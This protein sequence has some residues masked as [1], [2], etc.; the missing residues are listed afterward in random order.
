MRKIITLFLCLFI[1]NILHSQTTK[2]VGTGGNYSTLKLAFDAINSGTLTGAI[3]LQ[4]ISSTT[5]TTTANLNVSGSA[6]GGANYSSVLIYPT[7]SGY[8]IGSNI[9]SILINFN[10]AANVTI[11]GR[12]NLSGSTPDLTISN[13]SNSN[14]ATTIKYANSAS[15]NNIRYCNVL[16][17]S[18]GAGVATF[19]FS[20]S[21]SGS[22]IINNIIEYCNITNA[23]GNRPVNTILTSGTTGRENT[24]NIVRN[25]N[26]YNFLNPGIS[27][28]GVNMT[29]ASVNW[30][31]SGN[32][33]YETTSLI[34]NASGLTYSPIHISTLSNHTVSGNY[35]G[36]N[37]AQCGGTMTIN[38]SL[39]NYFCSIFITG[40]ATTASNVLN[41]TISN[42]NFTSTKDN[43]WDGIYI[44]D[45][46]VNV[47]G[48][49]IGAATGTNS[50]SITTPLASA[51]ATITGGVVNN[52]I[53]INVGGSGYTTAPLITFS[54]PPTGGTA[55][56][57]IATISGG[58]VTGI[59]VT[60]GGSGYVTAPSVYFDGIANNYSTSHG[61]IQNSNY[62]VNITNNNIGSITTVGSSSYSHGFESIYVRSVTG[63]TSFI[64]NVI[65]S[66][67]TPNS[68]HVSST[69]VNSLLKQDAYGIYSS[70]VGTTIITGNTIANITNEYSGINSG[71]RVRGIATIA[72]S[73]TITNNT[74]RNITTASSQFGN[75]T[76]A[77]IVGIAQTSSNTGTTQ[78]ITG[79]TVYSLSNSSASAKEDIYGIL[80][81]SPTA[82]TTTIS[83]NIIHSITLSSTNTSSYIIGIVLNYG[84]N[85]CVNN[86]VNLGVG[87]TTGYLISGI[88][89]E[90]GSGNNNNI[91]Y[92]TLYIGGT[93]SGTSSSTYA[94]YNSANT[95]TRNYKNN[96][97]MNVRSGGTT[98]NNFAVSLAGTANLLLDYNDYWAPGSDWLG[99]VGAQNKN[100]FTAFKNTTNQ[101]ANSINVDP[102]F[103]IAGGT[104]ISNYFTAAL[105]PGVAIT[106]ITT[107]FNGLSRSSTP[108]MGALENNNY[109]WQGGT[110]TD[111][112]TATNWTGGAVPPNGANITFA[113]SPNRNCVLDQ[114]RIIGDLT[115]GQSTYKFVVNG[116]QLTING[117]L[118][119]T[120]SAQIDATASSS[121]VVFAGTNAQSIPSSSFVSNT[122]DS[123]T[124][125]NANGLS[126][127]GDFT[128]NKGIA[129]IAGNFSLGPNTLTFNGIVTAMTGTVTGGSSTNMIIGGSGSNISMPAFILN[130]LTI[131]RT[132]GV[133]LYGNINISGVLTLTNGTLTVGANI[134]TLLNTPIRTNGNIDASN[135]GATLVFSNTS[136][137]TIPASI[138]TYA[139][140]NLTINGA[141]G[142]TASSGF[143]LNGILNLQSANPSNIKGC[144]DMW[145]GSAMDTLTMGAN[146][147]TIGTGDVTGIVTRNS[148]AV[149]TP[150]SF[151]NQFT[152]MNMSAGGALPNIVSCKITLVSSDLT[153]KTNAIHRYYDFIRTGGDSLTLVTLNL[154]YLNSELN[155]ATEGNLDLFDYHVSNVHI[156]D[157]GR[158]NDNISDKWVGLANLSLT[159]VCK[160]NSFN[161]KY[162][163]LGTSTVSSYTWVGA[164]TDWNSTANWAGGVVPVSGNHVVIPDASTTLYSPTLPSSTTIGSILIQAGGVLNGGTSTTLTL[165]AANNSWDNMGTFNAGTS[166]V[167]FTNANATMSDPTNFYNITVADGAKLTLSTDNIMRVSNV[168]SLSTTGVLNAANNHNTIEYNGGSQTIAFP[169]GSTTGY[170][171]LI[172]S[173]SGTKTMPSTALSIYGDFTISGT[174]TV[175][176]ASSINLAGEL[177]IGD[178]ATFNTGN[179][180]HY[181]SD[182]FDNS[183]IFNAAPGYTI[184]LNGII[185][186][187]IYGSSSTS[188]DNLT[189]N[190]SN[191]VSLLSN[192]N[193]NNVLT[194]ISGSFNVGSTTLGI[195]GTISSS[196]DSIIV[197]PLSSLSFGGSSSL[198]LNNNLF[199]TTPSILN[200]TINNS[201][202]V[203]LGNQSMTVNGA[204]S[205]QSGTLTVG[206]NSLTI[207]GSSPLR[208]SGNIDASNSGATINLN[209]ATAITLPSSIFTGTINNVNI[210][211]IGGVT[212]S[213]DL[214]IN[215]ILNLQSANPSTTKG[216]LDM[217]DGSAMKTLNMGANATT[218]GTGDVTGIVK[219]TSFT[220]NTTYT[221]GN[222]FTSMTIND[223]GVMPSDLRFKI[224]IG[225]APSWKTNA[226]ERYY[227]IIR[228]GGSGANVSL[229][230]HYLYSELDTNTESKLIIW[231]YHH[232]DTITKVEEHGKSNGSTNDD[233]VSITNRP[234]TYFDTSFGTHQWGLS[235]KESVGFVWQGSANSNWNDVN[236]WSSGTV[237]GAKSDVTIPDASTVLYHPI[238]QDGST[239]SV[240]TIF[241]QGGAILDG[242]TSTTLFVTGSSG[243][244]LNLGTFNA[245]TSTVVFTNA[246]ATMADPTDFYNVTIAT[247]A[248]LTLESNNIMRIAGTLTNNGTLNAASLP[249]LI[250]V[251]G[252]SQTLI[253]PNG[254]T[255]GYYHLHL[256]GNGTKTLPSTALNVQGDLHIMGNA[257]ATAGSATTVKGNLI[258]DQNTTF[259]SGGH[260]HYVNGDINCD[261]NISTTTGDSITLNGT[262]A[263][264]IYG[265]NSNTINFR[266]ITVAN[267]SNE[268]VSIKKH[269]STTDLTINN[270][271]KLI[272]TPTTNV[273]V[274]NNLINS[275]DAT[276]LILQSDP[277]GTA[278]LI[279]YS[280]VNGTDQRIMTPWPNV[281]STLGWHLL[282]SP[283]IN[284]SIAPNFTDPVSTLYDFFKW[285][286]STSQWLDQKDGSNNINTFEPGIGYLVSYPQQ[287]ARNF[288]G[289]L[290][291]SDVS[292]A[293]TYTAS[294]PGDRG[295]NLVGNP[296]PCAINGNIID[297]SKNNVYNNIYILEESTGI[298]YAWNGSVG[299]LN[300]GII[301]AMQGFWV[302]TNA[303]NPTL[304]IPASSRT[305]SNQNFYKSSQADVLKLTVTSP[306]T[307]HD[308]TVI[309]FT[310][311]SSNQADVNDALRLAGLDPS[312]VQ[313]YSYIGNDKYVIN[314]LAPLNGNAYSVNLGFEPKVDGSFSIT[315]ENI[316]TFVTGTTILL[317]DKKTNTL[318]DLIQNPVYN[319]SATINDSIQR[320]VVY[321][322][323]SPNSTIEPQTSNTNIYS[324]DNAIYV[325]SVDKIKSIN[326]FN[327]LGQVI[328]RTESCNNNQIKIP[329]SIV[330]ACYIVRVITD[331]KV[332]SEKVIVK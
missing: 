160:S 62:T 58:A 88:W 198:T 3:N 325:Q 292:P 64:N 318:Y 243:S 166:T 276:G 25:N 69:A 231:D 56:T 222:Q 186:Q 152:T 51:I 319:Y 61:M 122:I 112:A 145:N 87:L 246:N 191:G 327:M 212:S 195:N 144:L 315:A 8:I 257:T 71:S 134:L 142:I 322:N 19:F 330:D 45:G 63:T 248:S 78:S 131:N 125:N 28:Y 117:A 159:Y 259:N 90:S 67:T 250:E 85:N 317:Q 39:T 128:I 49:T 173:G 74:I 241:L 274:S 196:S 9:N 75:N 123:L 114:N 201:G 300:N 32:S 228:T 270:G 171:N 149:N 258:I 92:N 40:G 105:L 79:N 288:T 311:S 332:Y 192:T 208:T 4:I 97:F 242:G 164:S 83:G 249:N 204:L 2:T 180:N 175:T 210:L 146:A 266:H 281:P 93:V 223:G 193:I 42:I 167:V 54:A 101:D 293:L 174:T 37:A 262:I 127:N 291:K 286:E 295:W 86:I 179:F 297:W 239:D 298:Y 244:W 77:A 255:P 283:V 168:F 165:D 68:I 190:N 194:L 50:I 233:W 59:N 76:G 46:T 230:L 269:I 260:H 169:N 253:N 328:Y 240:K 170:H 36:G 272:V 60:Y 52:N 26:I 111:F 98:K 10:G 224:S 106:G 116:K 310:S 176:A 118:N 261:G 107:D 237:P 321:F 141:G 102:L 277:T 65:G 29:Y 155:G 18:T 225:A 189:I 23:G 53:T 185:P 232:N 91:Y 211:G 132:S 203:A 151:G 21:S 72:G 227:D 81:S 99:Q 217:W 302:R 278:S 70:G 108:K 24:G 109:V 148:F 290:N 305:H 5:E 96:I 47:T 178:G 73:N 43:P 44:N 273:T 306:N 312:A 119:F 156:D 308:A 215:G 55:P 181:I 33:F 163:M 294:G 15:S 197:C 22:G 1:I 202:G 289:T 256:N 139:V 214:T 110:S 275:S 284:Q 280:D 282:A 13:T 199:T 41:N 285:S 182:D 124:I 7:G 221:F 263:Q 154:H 103:T 188:F 27:S 137:I 130:N 177:T 213:D 57:A 326:V 304:T 133:S 309:H 205:L 236:N 184:T 264:N 279:H 100:T 329:M 247:G 113:S 94:L 66:L 183:G 161:A 147:T 20:T 104:A 238:L 150:Y 331:K 323:S 220:A 157:H 219:R 209:N 158:S 299:T 271:S 35:I 126:L 143:V 324:Y 34:P 172:L 153:W 234:I 12:V 296:F 17:S 314:S 138:F 136:A 226:V 115:N 267:T 82:T 216:S 229:S 307:T 11:D 6:G 320:F 245:E 135:S 16:G 14:S 121:K 235:N 207:A 252:S 140:N 287:V 187:S 84:V 162:W 254:P 265:T 89:D 303:L 38:A 316:N 200:L 95:S 31:I 206:T 301:P 80:V 251:N 268:G 129:L 30:T 120:N 48:N 313:M 218:T